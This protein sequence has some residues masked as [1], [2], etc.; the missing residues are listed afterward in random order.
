MASLYRDCLKTWKKKD[1]EE[2]KEKKEEEE[3]E[4]EEKEAAA[5]VVMFIAHPDPQ[6]S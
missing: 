3:E 5:D 6:N 4:K 2:G 1:K